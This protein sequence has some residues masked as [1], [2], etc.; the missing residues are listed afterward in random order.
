MSRFGRWA[1]SGHRKLRPRKFV[2]GDVAQHAD[3]RA[4][5]SRPRDKEAIYWQ[6]SKNTR[7]ERDR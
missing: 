2:G 3:H 6:L 4:E 7:Q 1:Y 5:P